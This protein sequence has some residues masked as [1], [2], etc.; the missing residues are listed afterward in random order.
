MKYPDLDFSFLGEGVLR[1]IEGFK[2]KPIEE[3]TPLTE[4]PNNEVHQLGEVMEEMM[5]EDEGRQQ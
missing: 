3:T 1:V 2:A 5:D 4:V